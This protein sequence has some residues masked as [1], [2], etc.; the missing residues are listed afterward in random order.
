[1][2]LALFLLLTAGAAHAAVVPPLLKS[3][4]RPIDDSD[5]V[6]S[7]MVVIAA[8]ETKSPIERSWEIITRDNSRRLLNPNRSP[9]I[10]I[11]VLAPADLSARAVGDWLFTALG[12]FRSIDIRKRVRLMMIGVKPAGFVVSEK[13]VCVVGLS[14]AALRKATG[15]WSQLAATLRAGA[16]EGVL[17]ADDAR[18][19]GTRALKWHSLGCERGQA[20]ACES[21]GILLLEH[22]AIREPKTAQRL[23]QR[24]CDLGAVTACRALSEELFKQKMNA[25]AEALLRK[26]CHAGSVDACTDLGDKL[27]YGVG[28]RQDLA[29][30]SRILKIACEHKDARACM[31]L[32]APELQSR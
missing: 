27:I 4:V 11:N 23:L 21:A 1:M 26:A 9:R 8:D 31:L 6:L 17:T 15:T 2:R 18:D 24:G 5:D 19:S 13:D 32:S 20:D 30:A 12:E 3:C 14:T 22:D 25:R 28:V 29:A 10:V 16:D 7:E